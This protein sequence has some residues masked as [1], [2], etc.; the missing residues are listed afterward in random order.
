MPAIYDAIINAIDAAILAGVS[1]P[2]ELT[3]SGRTIRYRSLQDLYEIRSRYAAMQACA[4]GKNGIRLI[5]I[6]TPG[7]KI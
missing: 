3:V 4:S 6:K 5:G 7:G 2:G 1:A